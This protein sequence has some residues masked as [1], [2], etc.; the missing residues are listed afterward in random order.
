MMIKHIVLIK[1]K[2]EIT[3]KPKQELIRR[4]TLKHK[5]PG[6]KISG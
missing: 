2:E 1:F 5:I 6:I 3:I 4:I